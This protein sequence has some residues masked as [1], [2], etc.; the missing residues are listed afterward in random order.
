MNLHE[1][2]VTRITGEHCT[3]GDFKNQVLLVVNTAS[4]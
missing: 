3:M 1:I 2:A 4:Q